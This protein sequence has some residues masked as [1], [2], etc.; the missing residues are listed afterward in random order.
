[1]KGQQRSASTI[2]SASSLLPDGNAVTLAAAKPKST[3][4]R[5]FTKANVSKMHCPPGKTEALFWDPNCRGF[6][7]RALPSGRRTWL[8]QYRNEH[9]RTRRMTLGDVSAVSPEAARRAARLQAAKVAQGADPSAE[10]K[11]TRGAE[12]LKSVIESYLQYAGTRQRPRSFIETKRHLL[13]HSAPLH[14]EPAEAVRRSQVAALLERLSKTSGPS[15]ANRCRA[16]LSAMWSW[17]LRTGHIEFDIN[18]VTFTIPNPE[19]SRSRTLTDEELRAIWSAT[20]GES[21]YSRIVRLCIL[22]GCR[23]EEIGGLQWEEILADRLL[24]GASRMKAGSE[25][26]VPLL[27][28]IVA[29]LPTR[30]EGA[31][32]KVFGRKQTGFSGWSNSKEALDLKLNKRDIEMQ[33]WRLHDLRRT[34]STRL[35]DAGAEPL[36]IEALLAHKQQG[37]AAVYNRASF[38]IA[39]RD[40]LERWHRLLLDIT[41]R[42]VGVL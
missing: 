36:V 6:G 28:A 3:Q 40:A 26:D 19:R 12:S 14:H 18:P 1:M 27:P 39:R 10:R 5:P 17:G 20:E 8:Y 7:L 23:R 13:K 41:E 33:P 34:F 25:H 30:P 11:E 21:D 38:R 4:P 32:G 9:Q 31:N 15:A 24:I 22:T 16:A 42:G 2:D 29:A 37:V 35:H